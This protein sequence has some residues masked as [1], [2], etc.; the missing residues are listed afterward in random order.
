MRRD[1]RESGLPTTRA[2]S[3]ELPVLGN[4]SPL[5]TVMGP[6]GVVAAV[7][8]DIGSACHGGSLSQP[9]RHGENQ[10]TT[11]ATTTTTTLYFMTRTCLG[12]R[13][14]QSVRW[15]ILPTTVCGSVRRRQEHCSTHNN[16]NKHTHDCQLL[17]TLQPSTA[18]TDTTTHPIAT[19]PPLNSK[20][21]TR[22]T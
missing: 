1:V 6:V 2:V 13:T 9:H 8:L 21:F 18:D 14:V 17:T 15:S 22:S 19:N 5:H 4:N 10:P 7:T 16:N 3:S 11:T 20:P 12:T